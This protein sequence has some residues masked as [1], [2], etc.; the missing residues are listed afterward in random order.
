MVNLEWVPLNDLSRTSRSIDGRYLEVISE[1]LASGTWLK[2]NRIYELEKRLSDYLDIL[3]VVGVANGTNALEIAFKS[4]SLCKRKYVVTVANAGAYASIAAR[5]VGLEII[6]CDIDATSHTMSPV[7]L[8]DIL[9]YIPECAVVATHLYGNPADI[10]TISKLCKISGAVLIED[11]AQSFGGSINGKK[12]GTFGDISTFSFYPT[13]NLGGIGDSG[14]LAT[15]SNSYYQKFL[16]L[17]EYGWDRK[18]RISLDSGT[19]S[20]LDEIQAA[21]LLLELE[22]INEMSIKR[23]NLMARFRDEIVAKCPRMINTDVAGAVPHL[24]VLEFESENCKTFFEEE[25]IQRRI[26]TGVHYPILDFDQPIFKS[27]NYENDFS[28]TISRSIV[29]RIITIPFFPELREE[30]ILRICD[31][32]RS[33]SH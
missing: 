14:A 19:N 28:H 26:E 18:Y 20:R 32:L 6:Y 8:N 31:L 7:K 17:R 13:K 27:T 11:C 33:A 25:A 5:N 23:R 3:H 12:L 4:I 10:E 9:K 21:V 16:Q 2:G 24:A 29:N 15:N 30:E 1:V 22:S